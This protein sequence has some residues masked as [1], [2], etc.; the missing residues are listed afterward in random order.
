[1]YLVRIDEN[2]GLIKEDPTN[3]SW[4]GI[5]LFR[6]VVKKYGIEALTVI[7]FSADYQ[8]PFRLYNEED[9]TRR[10]ME[11]IYENRD[12]LDFKKDKLLSSAL[13]KYKELQFNADLEQEQLNNEIKIRLLRK[14]SKANLEDNDTDIARHNKSL[15]NHE[16]TIEKFKK[17][18][19]RE[20]ALQES[21]TQ[22]GY[23]LSR[24]ENDIKSRKNSKFTTHG[25]NLENPDKL[26]LEK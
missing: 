25:T 21:I 2:T 22:S 8:S 19:D 5:S 3:D 12:E 4:M 15:Q 10:S 14:I 17:R 13:E 23:K 6:S 24:I 16:S 20:E 1:M 26:Q 18:F 9:R 7:A 11:E